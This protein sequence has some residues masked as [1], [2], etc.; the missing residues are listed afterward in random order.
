MA[1]RMVVKRVGEHKKEEC[2]KKKCMKCG[3]SCWRSDVSYC[4]DCYKYE[5]FESR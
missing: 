3:D 2:S 1:A 4:W 5:R